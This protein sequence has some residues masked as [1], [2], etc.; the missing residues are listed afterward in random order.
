[1]VALVLVRHRPNY[2]RLIRGTENK[3]WGGKKTDG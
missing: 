3:V 1:V 2:L